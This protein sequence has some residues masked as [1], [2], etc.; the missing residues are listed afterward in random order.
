[1]GAV[2]GR[3]FACSG[4]RWRIDPARYPTFDSRSV[5]G[6]NTPRMAPRYL[7]RII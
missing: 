1:M 4:F 5:S 3:Q 6:S 7:T 2:A